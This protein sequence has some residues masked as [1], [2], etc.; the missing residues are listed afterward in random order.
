MKQFELV[1][2][3]F[4]R[5]LGRSL[6]LLI[7]VS[8]P[9]FEREYHFINNT[10]PV[11]VDGVLYEPCPFDIIPPAQTET[12]GTQITMSNVQQ[13]VS[14]E[15]R[16]TV[17]S[18]QNIVITLFVVNIEAESAE[19]YAKGTFELMD[20]TITPETVTGSINIR[21]CLDINCGSI[22]YNRQLFPNLYM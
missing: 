16:K 5:Y 6:N 7:D 15:I 2:N 3:A 10:K 14:N 20:V 19:K 1:K 8:H 11:T 17:N 22:R 18:N 13:L 4:S 21:H 12:Q 9:E